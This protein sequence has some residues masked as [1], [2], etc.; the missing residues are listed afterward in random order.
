MFKNVYLLIVRFYCVY[1]A[2]PTNQPTQT[3]AFCWL[4]DEKRLTLRGGSSF[5][6]MLHYDILHQILHFWFTNQINNQRRRQRRRLRR[7][8]FWPGSQVLLL[9]F[10]LYPDIFPLLLDLQQFLAQVAAYPQQQQ[11]LLLQVLQHVRSV[12]R[13]AALEPHLA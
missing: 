7:L 3:H 1:R 4:L 5:E 11:V 8:R 10:D 12:R 9:Q 2:T 6:D 13:F